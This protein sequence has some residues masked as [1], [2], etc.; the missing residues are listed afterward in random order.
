MLRFF[1]IDGGDIS[2]HIPTL[3]PP[4]MTLFFIFDHPTCALS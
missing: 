4:K 3:L 1:N 2:I